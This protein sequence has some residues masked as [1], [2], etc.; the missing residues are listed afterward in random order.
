MQPTST[1]LRPPVTRSGCRL[2][3]TSPPTVRELC[4]S[5]SH[6]LQYP[7]LTLSLKTPPWETWGSFGLLSRSCPFSL[8]FGSIVVQSLSHIQLFCNPMDFST[9]GSLS[10]GFSKQEYWSGLPFPPPGDSSQPR[11][12]TWVSCIGRRILYHQG[13][14]FGSITKALKQMLI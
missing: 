7:P 6:P 8:L 13:S 1:Y 12:Q 2:L 11:N 4:T 9:S 14:P 10:T 5:W 3:I